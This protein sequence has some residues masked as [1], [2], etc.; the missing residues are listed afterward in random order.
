MLIVVVANTVAYPV[1]MVC[2]SLATPMPFVADR[3]G[4]GAPSR[5][6]CRILILSL[7]VSENTAS[8]QGR[9]CFRH[10][11]RS[12]TKKYTAGEVVHDGIRLDDDIQ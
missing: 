5:A 4:R 6:R 3:N 7:T 2:R 11:R 12:S 9:L 1:E 10:R 8:I